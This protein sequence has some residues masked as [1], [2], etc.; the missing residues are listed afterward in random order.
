MEAV[1]QIIKG[2]LC[3]SLLVFIHELGHFIVARYNGVKVNVFSIGFGKKLIQFKKGDTVYCLSMIPF[4]GYV[5][6]AGEN[7]TDEDFDEDD[8]SYFHKKS[9][10]ARAAIAFA[11]PAINIILAFFLLFVL[12][13]HGVHKPEVDNLLVGDVMEGT[14]GEK[15]GV[16][17][18]DIIIWVEDGPAQGWKHFDE[19]MGI[20]IGN[21]IPVKL[22]RGQDTL[23]LTITPE[24]YRDMGIGFSGLIGSY[25][26]LAAADPEPGTP[27]FMAGFKQNDTI[28]EINNKR[29]S[30]SYDFIDA[31]QQSKGDSLTV[32]VKRGGGEQ[33]LVV[34][35]KY[36]EE[37]KTYRI[38]LGLALAGVPEKFIQLGFFDAIGAAWHKGI[39]D[40]KKPF[41]FIGK[42]ITG[43]MKVKAMSGP[44]GIMQIMGL[45]ASI[46]D[47]LQL[48]AFISMSLGIMNLL[49][50]AITDGGILMFLAIELVRGKPLNKKVMISIQQF[51]MLFFLT[52]F[53]YVTYQDISRFSMFLPK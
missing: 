10:G 36:N 4:G 20:N 16:L 51:S 21:P 44:V 29:I 49:P 8:D 33:T 19:T 53:I 14:A 26:V 23:S 9:I 28:F 46:E 7:P 38:E 1:F 52:F 30:K 13:M 11:G 40:A 35:P 3:L 5:A 15:A 27:A 37:A 48:L 34:V 45:Q 24:E 39:E 18:G 22:V 42:L 2:L 41:I 31:I 12:F 25:K 50:L 32:K 17:S 43:S 6:M 47:L